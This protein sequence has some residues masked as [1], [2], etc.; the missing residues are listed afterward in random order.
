MHIV[1]TGSVVLQN[2]LYDFILSYLLEAPDH[3]AIIK[4]WQN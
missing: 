4:L 1:D 3:T 2:S